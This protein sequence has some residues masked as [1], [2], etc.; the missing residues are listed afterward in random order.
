[1]KTSE[2]F[3]LCPSCDGKAPLEVVICPYCASSFTDIGP[4]N[5]ST[6]SSSYSPPYSAERV[7]PTQADNKTN[8]PL[9]AQAAPL[10]KETSSFLPIALLTIGSNLIILSLLLLI[11]GR[12]GK[13]E[14]EWSSSY[15][16]LYLVLGAPLIFLGY[17]II[18]TDKNS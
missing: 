13:V 14:L 5:K 17:K 18:K 9:E 15:W 10:S 6:L 12:N 4:K 3:K 11:L 7:T 16:M 8:K 1:M 2:K